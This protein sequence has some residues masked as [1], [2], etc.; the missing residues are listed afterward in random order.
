MEPVNISVLEGDRVELECAGEGYPQ[1]RESWS[2]FHSTEFPSGA[3]VEPT[4][5]LVIEAVTLAHAG[6]YICK[7]V[8]DSHQELARREAWLSVKGM[9][10]Y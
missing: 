2:E 5:A 9:Y 10:V 7:L 1:P 6:R 4:G 3:H 8:D